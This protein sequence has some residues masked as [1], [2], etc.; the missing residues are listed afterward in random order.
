LLLARTRA[1]AREIGT[2]LALG[3][4]HARLARQFLTESALLSAVGGLFGVLVGFWALRPVLALVPA[5]YIGDGVE[6]H[7]SPAAFRVGLPE[8]KY[9]GNEQIL[10]FFREVLRRVRPLPGV[11]NAAASSIRPMEYYA[12][13]DFSIPGHPL[14]TAYGTATADYRVITPEYFSVLR[15]QL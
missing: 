5:H 9:R 13:R 14:N 1:R 6:I 8:T 4:T 10:G 12:L 7:A 3:A 2:R 15:A 11:V